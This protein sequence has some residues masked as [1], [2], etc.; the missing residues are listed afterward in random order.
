[1]RV[2]DGGI[3]DGRWGYEAGQSGVGDIFSWFV[4][5]SVPA[6]YAEAAAAG[7]TSTS[8][9]YQF[10]GDTEDALPGPSHRSAFGASF[11]N[12]INSDPGAARS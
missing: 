8:P 6:A 12:V 11:L 1:M 10:L 7:G 4:N 5:N 9:S 3:L 2:A